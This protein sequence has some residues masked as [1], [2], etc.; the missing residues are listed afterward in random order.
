[1][2]DQRTILSGAAF[3]LAAVALLWAVFVTRTPEKRESPISPEVERLS[4]R[5]AALERRI[6]ELAN[7]G[8]TRSGDFRP[9]SL[10]RGPYRGEARTVK[11]TDEKV[12]RSIPGQV[13][14]LK[15]EVEALKGFRAESNVLI[16]GIKKKI[17]EEKKREANLKRLREQY[18]ER[19]RADRKTYGED[20]AKIEDLFQKAYR[21]WGTPQAMETLKNLLTQYPE[22]NRAGCGAL[23]LGRM[24]GGAGDMQQAEIYMRKA[25]EEYGDA[26]YSD[27]VQVGAMSRYFLGELYARQGR[28]DE[29]RAVFQEILK[30]YPG[31]IDHRGRPL[32]ESIQRALQ[33]FKR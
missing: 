17:V 2:A 5:I 6:N 13:E 21:Q 11:S 14:T 12:P 25:A 26:F 33:F 23:N 1:L 10:S 16:E 7:R 20:I 8:G 3:I 19:A 32:S 31:A 15:K 28:Y 27:G 24:Y 30:K 29:A 4:G 22:A 9:E 18:M